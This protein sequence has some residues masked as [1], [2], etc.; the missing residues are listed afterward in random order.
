[1]IKSIDWCCDK[2]LPVVYSGVI[3][4]HAAKENIGWAT[5][6]FLICYTFIL[7]RPQ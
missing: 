2:A 1:M 6:A 7:R 3:L 5:A 4:L